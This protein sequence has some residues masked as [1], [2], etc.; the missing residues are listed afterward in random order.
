[1]FHENDHVLDH[2]DDYLHA[3]LGPADAVHLEQHIEVCPI[4]KVA[5]EE[6][7][8]RQAAYAS[9]PPCEAPERLIQATL[10]SVAGHEAR[11]RK[12]LRVGVP[13][14]VAVL[15]ASV[16]LLVGANVYYATLKPSPYEIKLLGQTSLL[17]GTGGSIRIQLVNHVNGAPLANVPV[18]LE[19]RAPDTGN[20]ITLAE[21]H[22]DAQGTG[23]PRFQIPNWADGDYHLVVRAK[24]ASDEEVL[25]Q[26]VHLKR[27]WRLMLSSDKPVYQPGQTIHVRSLALRQP[28]LRPV[29]GQEA[30]ITITDPKGNMIFKHRD[31]GSRFGI[32]S[33]DCDLADEI[34]EGSYT[35]ACKIGDTESKQTVEVRKYVLPKFKIDVQLDQPF[36]EPGQ[37]VKGTIQADY[38]FGKPVVDGDATIEVKTTDVKPETV[39]QI[40]AKTD[41]TGTATFD[42]LVPDKLVG[43]EQHSG[44]ARIAIEV[45]LKDTAEQ[46]QSKTVSRVVTNQPLRIEV[47]PE[48]GFLVR[49]V[50]NRVYLF[51]SYA[52]GRPARADVSVSGREAPLHTDALGTTSF[53]VA[54]QDPL[55]Y[56]LRATDAD[57]NIGRK[58][59]NLEF[60]YA[61]FV[62]RTD[63]AVYNGGETVQ[64]TALGG[65]VEPIFLDLLKDGQT[66]LTDTIECQDGRGEHAID[67]PPELFGT[68][69]IC[70]YRFGR[71]GLP[72]RK[73]RALFIRPASQLNIH[74]ELDKK[75]YRPGK[76]AKVQFTL[77]DDKSNPTPGALSLA[78][79]DEAVFSVLDQAPGMEK[80]FYLLESQL[81]KP[82]YAIYPWAPDLHNAPPAEIDQF[83][84]ALFSRTVSAEKPSTPS[85]AH[86]L[87]VDNFVL[88]ESDI[89]RTRDRGLKRIYLF[90]VIDGLIIALVLYCAVW[91]FC[92]K[93]V[94]IALHIAGGILMV[95]VFLMGMLAFLVA[96]GCGGSAPPF[97]G[98]KMAANE[99]AMARQAG[100]DRAPSFGS[101]KG[102]HGR[103]DGDWGPLASEISGGESRFRVRE[104]FPET[105][106]WKPELITDE[107]GRATLDV[108][109][110]DSIT[111]WRLTG[112]AVSGDGRLGAMQTSLRVFQPFFVDLNLPVSLTRNDE[113]AVP[114]VVYNYLDKPQTVK[115]TLQEDHGDAWFTLQ[116]ATQQSLN[117]QPGEVRSIYYRIKA[118]R[119]GGHKLEVHAEGSNVAD[120]IRRSIEVVPDGRRVETVVNGTLQ[121]PVERAFTVPADAIDGSPKLFVRIYPST[122]SQLVEGLDGI[123]QRPYGCFEQTSSTTYPNVLALDYLRRTKKSVPDVE[124]KARQYIHL[125]YQRLLGFEVR[126][127]GFDWFGRPPAN[128]T[129]TA[130]GLMEFQDMARVHDV[131]PNVINRTRDWLMKKRNRDGSWSPDGHGMHQDPVGGIGDTAKLGVTAYVA[132]AIFSGSSSSA[133]ARVT[134]DYLLAHRPE[135]IDDPHILALVCNA[136]YAIDPKGSEV[137]P[138]LDRLESMKKASEDQRR[139]WWEQ[140]ATSRTTFY[141][142]GR[143]GSIETTALAALALMQ[144]PDYA[145]TTRGALT[146]IAEQKDRFGTWQT[147]QAT[148]LS[149]KALLAATDKPL[150]GDKERRIEVRLNDR[151]VKE[152]V[153]PADQAEVMQQVNVSPNLIAGENRL[154]LV[155]TSGTGVGYQM[156]FRYYVPGS[157]KTG[158]R[159]PLAISI[160]YDRTDLAVGDTVKAAAT[161]INQMDKDAPMVILDL[162]IPAGFTMEAED[163]A[164]L[165]AEKK[166]EKFQ[167]NAR[168][169]VVYL[170]GLAPAKPLIL[171]YTLRAKMPV[172]V[173]VPAGRVYEYYDESKQ[174]VA[175]PARMT[176]T[177]K[178]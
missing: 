117:L 24:P 115:L 107:H 165:V 63:K 152:I 40:I 106:L 176:V 71:D 2:V 119:V 150:G 23:Q 79:V 70:A 157:D 69:E 120:A 100:A 41:G 108:D 156:A 169:A 146:W 127:G 42:F 51:V 86:S 175:R 34:L 39:K 47:I 65:G 45:T 110:A 161:V 67:L 17:A 85:T 105:L 142:S 177:E 75:E 137:K 72:V 83:E 35:I 139:V 88:K 6:A 13:S 136:L 27:S 148:V 138:Y 21:F 14:V 80:T 7:R 15:A 25:E 113:V 58:A 48:N 98:R 172:Q 52:D 19:L 130:Y 44:D 149:L 96:H 158:E 97:V 26:T 87:D 94:T 133:E 29:A 124:A 92:A 10:K 33:A 50:S 28:D 121:Q 131:D 135:K 140:P 76:S 66:V 125:G 93:E 46:K 129:L 178:K 173:A 43:K 160:D 1:M 38:F 141:G 151:L 163:L 126:D 170:R 102:N 53:E 4:C 114:V 68:L 36:Y 174:G 55:D 123:F 168:S 20:A 155:E 32:A 18:V 95:P 60:G 3:A 164:K 166:I 162:P 147:T 16:L 91:A 118:A 78:A 74:A 30:V 109:L 101:Q 5:L 54:A 132:W 81:L 49:G 99:V 144:S 62:L 103:N 112:S 77:T 82:V 116:G 61:D 171:T 73:T 89:E 31:P 9:L 37:K 12:L 84:L 145:N 153:I 111:T 167:L 159:E 128:L 11:R 104:W 56:T 143:A 57:G 64:L 134:Q 22:T 90:W 154:A 8:K 59:V 122:F